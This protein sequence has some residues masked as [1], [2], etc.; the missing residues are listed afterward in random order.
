MDEIRPEYVEALNAAR[1]NYWWYVAAAIP[2]L[3]LVPAALTRKLGCLAF[4][5]AYFLSWLALNFAVQHYWAAKEANA[6]TDAEWADVTADTAQLYAGVTTIPY[7]FVYVSIV[8]ALIYTTVG[9][10]RS[11]FKP[12]SN[13][14]S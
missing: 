3:L 5:A 10:V 6:V 7:A 12:K 1:W 2:A 9:V 4:P 14:R 11:M 13:N 8:G